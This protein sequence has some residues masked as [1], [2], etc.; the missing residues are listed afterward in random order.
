MGIR[1]HPTAPR[2]PLQNGHVQRLI[3]SMRRECLDHIQCPEQGP[4]T[5]RSFEASMNVRF[6]QK[7]T[8]A[9]R[10]DAVV[11]II[12]AHTMPSSTLS[13]LQILTENDQR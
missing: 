9:A 6:G 12:V 2:S 11:A 5:A 7:A 3:G 13:I 10:P 4:L 8:K 1:D